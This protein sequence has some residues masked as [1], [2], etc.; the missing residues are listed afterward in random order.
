VARGTE[1]ACVRD[2]GSRRS[3]ARCAQARWFP[4]DR[5]RALSPAA[6]DH[7]PSFLTGACREQR[8]STPWSRI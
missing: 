7:S 2:R 3:A 6:A 8:A 4:S 1:A 5:E